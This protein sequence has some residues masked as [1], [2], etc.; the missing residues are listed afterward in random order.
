MSKSPVAAMLWYGSRVFWCLRENINMTS[1]WLHFAC[2]AVR[3]IG[4]RNL[5]NGASRH[6]HEFS[7][8]WF[9]PETT[10]VRC[11]A[12]PGVLLSLKQSPSLIICVYE[13]PINSAGSRSIDRCTGSDHHL[14]GEALL[15]EDFSFIEINCKRSLEQN[16][17]PHTRNR[18]PTAESLVLFLIRSKCHHTRDNSIRHT[19]T[20]FTPMSRTNI[21]GLGTLVEVCLG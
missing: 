17:H 3:G 1:H 6:P 10:W 7:E 9:L 15:L 11:S 18:S 8:L 21:C 16:H 2:Q 12:R 14:L 13:I 20:H 4:Q 5:R 19:P